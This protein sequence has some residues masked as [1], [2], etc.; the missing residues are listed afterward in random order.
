MVKVDIP[1]KISRI[2]CF[3]GIIF[4]ILSIVFAIYGKYGRAI[5]V[6]VLFITT[7]VHWNEM[8]Y[9]SWAHLIDMCVVITVISVSIYAARKYPPL[10]W[11]LY[12]TSLA[13]GI[14]GFIIDKIVYVTNYT[15][16]NREIYITCIIHIVMFHLI[17][18]V[19]YLWGFLHYEV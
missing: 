6:F 17:V 1:S 3:S 12:G 16:S 4:L 18:P 8:K 10:F 11:K 7:C 13:I 15:Y 5:L 19:I 9:G 2:G 14:L